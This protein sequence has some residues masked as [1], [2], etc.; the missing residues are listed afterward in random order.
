MD[1]VASRGGDV[2]RPRFPRRGRQLLQGWTSRAGETKAL[3]GASQ[4]GMEPVPQAACMAW[5]GRL[6]AGL[7]ASR[8]G[9]LVCGCSP[10]LSGKDRSH[11]GQEPAMC[12]SLASLW[13]GRFWQR[14]PPAALGTRSGS[15]SPWHGRFWGPRPL[16]SHPSGHPA[17]WPSP[18]SGPWPALL[19]RGRGGSS[20][21]RK[22]A[23]VPPRG[24]VFRSRPWAAPR[25]S[26]GGSGGEHDLQGPRRA[27]SPS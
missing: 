20:P 7:P 26:L 9:G 14:A 8:R 24:R 19:Q 6:L 23:E 3:T 2:W 5:G 10:A 18:C 22:R 17:A 16:V 21:G 1:G 12:V 11:P 13:R 25:D 27:G 15:S 4:A